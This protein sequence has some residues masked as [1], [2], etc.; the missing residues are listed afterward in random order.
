MGDHNI[1][2]TTQQCPSVLAPPIIEMSLPQFINQDV[3][4]VV[5]QFYSSSFKKDWANALYE[6]WHS[7]DEVLEGSELLV[8]EN[9]LENLVEE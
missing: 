9:Q 6:T 2:F 8:I 7:K 4:I 5:E 3:I 1:K